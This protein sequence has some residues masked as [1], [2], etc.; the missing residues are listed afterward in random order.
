VP[1]LIGAGGGEVAFAATRSL[2]VT[3]V[4]LGALLSASGAPDDGIETALAT[5]DEPRLGPAL[6]ALAER[7]TIVIS[8]RGELRGLAEA[9]ALMLM[10]LARMPALGFESGQ[11]RHGPL[12]L[13]GPDVGVLL[14]RGPGELGAGTAGLARTVIQAG[15]MPVVFDCSGAA[16]VPGAVTVGFPACRGLA[17]ALIMLPAL[18][19]LIIGIAERKVAR[20]GEPVRSTKITGIEHEA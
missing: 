17:A 11:F 9:N 18:Q 1:C 12:E 10:E 15:G 13:L 8:G 16:A 6:Q 7:S 5:P 3:V 14:L 2:L 19:R 20:V 4:L